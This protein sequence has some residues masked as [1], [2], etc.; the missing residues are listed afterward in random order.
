MENSSSIRRTILHG[1]QFFCGIGKISKTV[2]K[3]PGKHTW[4]SF[5][6]GHIEE[7]FSIH[8]WT[9]IAA[10]RRQTKSEPVSPDADIVRTEADVRLG[11]G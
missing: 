3:Q 2:I 6:G 11:G 9:S 8:E 7:L 1:E 4:L 10:S 5:L